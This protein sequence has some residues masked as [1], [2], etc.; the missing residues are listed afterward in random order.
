[1]IESKTKSRVKIACPK[2]KHVFLPDFKEIQS[3]AGR[4]A[5][6]KGANFERNLAKKFAKWWPGNY[7]FKKTP[8]SGGSILKEGWDLAADICTN[9]P[10][11][12]YSIEAK[13]QPSN[14]TGIHN[15]FSD[16]SAVWK[17]LEQASDDCPKHRKPLLVFNRFDLPTYCATINID[18]V[19]ILIK[20]DITFFTFNYKNKCVLIWQL[21][22]MLS[23]DPQWWKND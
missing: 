16:K 11:F 17:W 10:D 14:F 3:R 7:E 23:S 22:D 19:S 20:C 6:R 5:R 8:Q 18:I 4:S 21:K 12:P 1:M 15:L 2:C 9:A 13:N